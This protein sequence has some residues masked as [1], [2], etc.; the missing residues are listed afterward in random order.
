MPTLASS[1]S[2]GSAQVTTSGEPRLGFAEAIPRLPSGLL[3]GS[4]GRCSPGGGRHSRVM[5][6][7]C[8]CAG[9][10]G[11]YTPEEPSGST[12]PPAAGA[13]AFSHIRQCSDLSLSFRHL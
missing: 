9:A 13:P 2:S 6:C 3:G 5:V 12:S 7:V 1:G 10:R 8:V 4:E 11:S